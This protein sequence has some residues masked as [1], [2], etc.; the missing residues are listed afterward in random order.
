MVQLKLMLNSKRPSTVYAANGKAFT[1][2]PGT[3]VLNL[4]YE[5]Y[6]ALAKTLHITPAKNL[7]DSKANEHIED[8]KT[9]VEE[10][11]PKAEE[12]I[13]SMIKTTT[14]VEESESAVTD[15]KVAETTECLE[16]SAMPAE[17]TKTNEFVEESK[18]EEIEQTKEVVDY[19]IWSYTKLK[20]EYKSIT[21]KTCKLKKDEIIKF[22]QEQT[23]AEQ[24]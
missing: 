13:E 23:N 15:N 21:G 24:I 17:D 14:H 8:N 9:P 2:R 7:K 11:T 10:S 4:S 20:A 22:L 18:A 16:E 3:N 19:S 5:D 6:I 1:L 12:H